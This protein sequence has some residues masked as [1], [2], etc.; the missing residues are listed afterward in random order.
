M[1]Y[2][3]YS[4]VQLLDTTSGMREL[5]DT[6]TAV[7]KRKQERDQFQQK[8]AFE[9]EQ[10]QR[11]LAQQQGQLDY[12]NK[13]EE[14]KNRMSELEF[15]Q[16]QN[17]YKASRAEQIRKAIA[18]GNTQLADQLA[19]ET[20]LYDPHSGKPIAKG[21]LE[22]GP[23][24]DIGPAPQAPEAPAFPAKEAAGV[25]P[26]IAQALPGMPPELGAM[27][28][29]KQKAQGAIPL[30]QLGSELPDAMPARQAEMAG[31]AERHKGKMFVDQIDDQ[32]IATLITDEGEKVHVRAKK[33]WQEGALI[34]PD[35]QITQAA[36]AEGSMRRFD[37]SVQGA[38][39]E[40]EQ[41]DPGRFDAAANAFSDY[42][43]Q[44]DTFNKETQSLP[45]RQTAYAAEKRAAEA[46]RPYMLKFGE[47]DPGQAIDMKSQRY[48]GRV[49][50]ADDFVNTVGQMN[51]KPAEMEAAKFARAAILNGADPDKVMKQFQEERTLGIKQDYGHAE[52]LLR[53]TNR[54]NVAKIRADAPQM[55]WKERVGLGN[56]A[57]NAER[58]GKGEFQD[59]LRNAGYKTEFAGLKQLLQ[60]A[61]QM[62]LH[63]SALDVAAG[64]QFARNA[65]GT[66]VLSNQDFDQFW[67]KIGSGEERTDDWFERAITGRMGEG[68]R[69]VVLKAIA[70]KLNGVSDNMRNMASQADLKYGNEPWY[71]GDRQM[72]FGVVP[73]LPPMGQ[74]IGPRIG[75]SGVPR[76]GAPPEISKRLKAKG[77]AVDKLLDAEERAQSGR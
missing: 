17:T 39:F 71:P 4:P 77:S 32:G 2:L 14:R 10:E 68:K 44:Q 48:G 56:L 15:N 30:D 6:L 47:N 7:A 75:A 24:R 29:G 73:D 51:L 57:L 26:D 33:G 18:A 67:V 62:K 13:I 3:D 45:A 49:L 46:E 74:A 41:P 40:G 65:Q 22:Q 69:R 16:R 70:A 23:A 27:M 34:G 21:S 31:Q 61:Q 52:G 63:N 5:G 50:A 64:A 35:G 8:L 20:E 54:E 36:G 53:D 60:T 11:R 58:L 19:N 37:P 9:R 76:K 66:G 42:Q 55:D 43:G 38:R 28:R 25:I 59:Y 12:Q 72:Y 1:A